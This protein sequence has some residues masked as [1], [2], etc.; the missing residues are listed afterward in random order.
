MWPKSMVFIP[1]CVPPPSS[2]HV[3]V[4]APGPK[5]EIVPGLT[6]EE[7]E[8]LLRYRFDSEKPTC[9]NSVISPATKRVK[10]ES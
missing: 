4:C 3:T 9:K 1:H 6:S 7:R 10:T 5:V 2:S 8:E